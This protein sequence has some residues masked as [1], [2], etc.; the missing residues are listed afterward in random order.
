MTT[1]RNGRILDTRVLEG[2]LFIV[3]WDGQLLD[4][5]VLRQPPGEVSG[6]HRR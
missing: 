3:E 2:E 4:A 1:A 5:D 6:R